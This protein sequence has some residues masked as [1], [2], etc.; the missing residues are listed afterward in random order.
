MTVTIGSLLETAPVPRMDARILLSFVTGE[1]RE[2]QIAHGEHAL[3]REHVARFR[4]LC[5]QKAAGVP[6]AYLTGR[7]WF[8]RREFLVNDRVMIPR[9]E[10]EELVE[11]AVAYLRS[12]RTRRVVDAGTGSGAI[13][14]TIAAEVPMARVD[15]IDVSAEALEVARQNAITLGVADSVQLFHC[16]V[17][18][19]RPRGRYDAIVANLPYVPSAALPRKPASAGFEPPIALDGGADGLDHYRVLL[20]RAPQLLRGGGLLL[21]EAA[22]ETAE[23]LR[24]LAA[25]ECA[26]SAAIVHADYS[27]RPRYVALLA[28]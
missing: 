7:A 11:E 17:G 13:A 9:P 21:M 12:S 4:E 24:A 10:T 5:A 3:N 25:R 16:S 27:G 22:S 23:P 14:C 15:A 18:E 8:Y 26:G 28:A 19:F 20:A 6:V 1:T 2:S